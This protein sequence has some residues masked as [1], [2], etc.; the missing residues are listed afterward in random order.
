MSENRWSHLALCPE[1][2]RC[3]SAAVSQRHCSLPLIRPRHVRG[4]ATQHHALLFWAEPQAVVPKPV[5]HFRSCLRSPPRRSRRPPG[6]F[7]RPT[8]CFH[9][10]FL[11]RDLLYLH[12]LRWLGLRAGSD[13]SKCHLER[14]PTLSPP[15]LEK[16][17]LDAL[18]SSTDHAS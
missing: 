16:R 5:G 15:A 1:D 7:R 4:L 2:I 13:P 11:R 6:W 8:G 12:P 10:C 9:S 14:Y 18:P 3:A 17:L